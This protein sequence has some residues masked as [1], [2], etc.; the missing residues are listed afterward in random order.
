MKK[1]LKIV[2]GIILGIVV[3]ALLLVLVVLLVIIWLQAKFSSRKEYE[4]VMRLY[5]LFVFAPY[6][7]HLQK[8]HVELGVYLQYA[9]EMCN[10]VLLPLLVLATDALVLLILG[11]ALTVT[12]P[13]ITFFSVI[14]LLLDV[15]FIYWI[16]R[17]KNFQAGK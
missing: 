17:K 15:L 4:L 14:C 13:V 9:R 5:H 11:A 16:L 7:L 10:R 8:S 2:G 6:R 12:M 1:I 3:L